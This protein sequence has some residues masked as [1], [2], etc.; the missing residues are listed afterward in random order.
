M[1]LIKEVQDFGFTPQTDLESPS[2]PPLEDLKAPVPRLSSQSVDQ[3]STYFVYYPAFPH[4]IS[5]YKAIMDKLT[6]QQKDEL[7][8]SLA[9]L[10]LYDG[11]VRYTRG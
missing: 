1:R 6:E 3:P 8:T 11:E 2:C 5:L 4:L 9:I 10:A 7:A